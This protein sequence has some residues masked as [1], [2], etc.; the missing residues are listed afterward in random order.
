MQARPT[1][2]CPRSRWTGSISSRPPSGLV[3]SPSWWWCGAAA[4]ARER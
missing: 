4:S 3:A 1:R 2:G